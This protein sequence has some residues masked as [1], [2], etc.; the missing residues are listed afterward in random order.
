VKFSLRG[1]ESE[2]VA[3]YAIDKMLENKRIIIPGFSIKTLAVLSKIA[4]T[5]IVLYMTYKRQKAKGK[6]N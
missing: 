4:P 6:S 1:L 2:Y 5:N 3:K